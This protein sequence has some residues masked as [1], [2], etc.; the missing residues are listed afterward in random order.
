MRQLL[1]LV[2]MFAAGSLLPSSREAAAR[3]SPQVLVEVRFV[4]VSGEFSRGFGINDYGEIVGQLGA[5]NGNPAQAF[6]APLDGPATPLPGLA[7]NRESTAYGINVRGFIAGSAL[8]ANGVEHGAIWSPEGQIRDVHPAGFES[9]VL[10][11]INDQNVAV[12]RVIDPATGLSR[13]WILPELGDE[14]ILQ[15]A[16]GKSQSLI[17]VN[18][19][20]QAV[21]N[22]TDS[23]GNQIGIYIP[24]IT[25]PETRH[26]IVP[27]GYFESRLRGIDASGA[28]C[29]SAFKVRNSPIPFVVKPQL[30]P[31]GAISLDMTVEMA[32]DL[33]AIIGS[34]QGASRSLGSCVSLLQ[35]PDGNQLVLG[36]LKKPKEHRLPVLGEIPL[37]GPLFRSRGKANS[38]ELL[39]FTTATIIDSTDSDPLGPPPPP[40]NPRGGLI[41]VRSKTKAADR[42]TKATIV[43]GAITDGPTPGTFRQP[44]RVRAKS[45]LTGP[46]VL[47]LDSVPAGVRLL[48]L[49]GVTLVTLPH[50]RPFVR[51]GSGDLKKGKS[52]NV[53][54]LF[55][56]PS[57]DAISY[58]PTVLAGGNL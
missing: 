31:G 51:V 55:E 24:T 15:V 41:V 2:L 1:L 30:G 56:A 26:P 7:A 35:V 44:V 4:T 58:T 45:D 39:L 16:A 19:A 34:D 49:S 52:R 47:A 54:L 36:G 50:G 11:G 13:P 48:N 53:E 22:Q 27:P 17:G 18:N 37:V 32:G 5:A 9:S 40:A 57:S 12:G 29:G 33:G 14:V 42:T 3:P 38:R 43:P 8:D 46:V 10:Y 28:L 6:R 20:G 21:G 23:F 25:E